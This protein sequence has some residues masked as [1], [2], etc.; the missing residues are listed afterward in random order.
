MEEER[1]VK[2]RA[3]EGMRG[4]HVDGK[5][6]RDKQETDGGKGRKEREK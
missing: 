1:K 3:V 4:S 2:G 5:L 6:G